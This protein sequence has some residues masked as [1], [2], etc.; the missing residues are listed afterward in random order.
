M[1]KEKKPEKL[2]IAIPVTSKDTIEILKQ[3]CNLVVTGTTPSSSNFK[4]VGQ[5]YQEFKPVDDEQ[6]I[7]ICNKRGLSLT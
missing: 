3:E 4:T 7:E 1:D 2:V 6:V 5:Y